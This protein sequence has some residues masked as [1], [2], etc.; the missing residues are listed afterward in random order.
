MLNI[1]NKLFMCFKIY[2]RY[3]ERAGGQ[4]YLYY[5]SAYPIFLLFKAF[6]LANRNI[7][8]NIFPKR[9]GRPKLDQETIDLILKLKKLNPTWGGKRI[10]DE[11]K[12]KKLG[13]GYRSQLF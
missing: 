9:T 6:S 11:L 4:I 8:V 10:S 5:A 1:L 13:I 2:L 12:K 3:F 7:R